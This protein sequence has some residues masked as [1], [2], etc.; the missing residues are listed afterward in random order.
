[1]TDVY[2]GKIYINVSRTQYSIFNKMMD[3]QTVHVTANKATV[4][5]NH[6]NGLVSG[7][8]VLSI[9]HPNMIVF[10]LHIGVLLRFSYILGNW[11]VVLAWHCN[12]F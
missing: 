2:V 6:T 10:Y 7:S 1:L 8:D 12:A 5:K 4:C 3:L 11:L 9:L